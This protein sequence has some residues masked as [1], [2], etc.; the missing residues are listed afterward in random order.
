[1]RE[2]CKTCSNYHFYLMITGGPY[3]YAGRIPC[4]NCS[5]FSYAQDNYSPKQSGGN[6]ADLPKELKP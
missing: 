5:R 1:M 6:Y 3:G 4:V 2:S